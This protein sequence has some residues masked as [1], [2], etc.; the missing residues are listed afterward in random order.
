MIDVDFAR[1]RTA[2]QTPGCDWP[3]WHICLVGK[4]DLTP[5]ILKKEA[6]APKKKRKSVYR[7]AAWKAQIS[8]GQIERWAK[9]HAQ[10]RTR[11]LDIVQMRKDGFSNRV[12]AKKYGIGHNTVSQII[13]RMQKEIDGRG[14]PSRVG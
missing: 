10:T 3:T 1:P 6:K 14:E 11:D 2:C 5:E 8:M 12:I 7:D 9:V 4:E 13:K